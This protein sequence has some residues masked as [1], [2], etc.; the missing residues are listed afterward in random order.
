MKKAWYEIRELRKKV[1]IITDFY[2]E[3]IELKDIKTGEYHL[4]H[5]D[6]VELIK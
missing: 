3:Y 2:C 1:G 4:I 5:E 6:K